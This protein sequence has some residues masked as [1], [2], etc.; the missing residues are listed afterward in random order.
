MN[1]VGADAVDTYL[2][3]FR[4]E[5]ATLSPQNATET[6]GLQPCLT[7]ESAV[8]IAAGRFESAMW[9]FDGISSQSVGDQ[10]E[11]LSLHSGLD[12]LLELLLPKLELIQSNFG[13]H[14]MYWWCG[15][16][17]ESFDGSSTF[18][19]ELLRKLAQF[20]APVILTSYHE[21]PAG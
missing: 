17:Q 12:F 3:E 5:G 2:I 6:L 13:H 7:R 21:R 1:K 15:H 14:D 16:F 9:S 20:G 19:T 10:K 18:P 4:I 11:W 8:G